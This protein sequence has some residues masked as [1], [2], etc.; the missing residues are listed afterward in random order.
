MSK[1][2]TMKYFMSKKQLNK[3]LPILCEKLN[4]AR[5]DL[6]SL[7]SGY[8]ASVLLATMV[9]IVDL[10]DLGV[11]SFES[12]CQREVQELNNSTARILAQNFIKDYDC[13]QYAEQVDTCFDYIIDGAKTHKSVEH[14]D[15]FNE[16]ERNYRILGL[17]VSLHDVANKEA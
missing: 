7:M 2:E 5:E 16:I 6:E 14:L 1:M 13:K 15:N 3:D 8:G 10:K 4:I 11:Y 17:S 9:D 12:V